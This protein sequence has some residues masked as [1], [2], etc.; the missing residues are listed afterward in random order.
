MAHTI[1]TE[2][3]TPILLS[4]NPMWFTFSTTTPL[5]AILRLNVQIWYRFN[6]SGAYQLLITLA[7]PYSPFTS[8]TLFNVQKEI[9]DLI[10]IPPLGFYNGVA[11]TPIKVEFYL[12]TFEVNLGNDTHL[13]GNVSTSNYYA[14]KGKTD[15][16]K[17]SEL[18]AYHYAEYYQ[19]KFLTNMPKK[20][21]IVRDQAL[22]FSFG[23]FINPSSTR[24]FRIKWLL[25]YDDGYSVNAFFDSLLHEYGT[26]RTF[27]FD[28]SLFAGYNPNPLAKLSRIS[29]TLV[30][31]PADT[32][33]DN[34][35]YTY[36]QAPSKRSRHF[37]WLNNL[38]GYDFL[39]CTGILE[40]AM[41]VEGDLYQ[42]TVAKN[43]YTSQ[44]T[45]LAEANLQPEIQYKVNTGMKTK[46]EIEGFLPFF[47]SE[48]T[49]LYRKDLTE[50]ASNFWFIPVGKKTDGT[51]RKDK[52][53]LNAMGFEFFPLFVTNTPYVLK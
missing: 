52:D 4:G 17:A 27:V 51:Y 45:D 48:Q 33:L 13:G 11:T 12:T 38:G 18:S 40:Q 49:L 20:R 44:E 22:A 3:S 37:I 5:T 36:E 53:Y 19:N 10:Q 23:N 43:N 35:T 31:M 24:T 42:K 30:L 41:S 1:V 46:G 2:P 39:T 6:A 9:D 21:T 28:E 16:I 8:T 26:V 25:T 34:I 15:R 47:L 29:N 14:I 32:V 7:L 50:N